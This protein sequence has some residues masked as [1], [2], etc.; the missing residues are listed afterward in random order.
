MPATR[1][2]IAVEGLLHLKVLRSPHAHARIM[3]IDRTKA[4][5]VPGVVAVYTW[6]DV[7]RRLFSSALHEDHLVDPDDMLLLDNVVRFVGQRVAAVVAETEAR[8]RGRLPRARGR[9]RDPAG[10]VRSGVGDGARR[11]APARQGRAVDD[12]SNIFCTLQGEIGDVAKGFAR[13]RRHPRADLFDHPRAARPSRDARIDRLEGRRQPLACPHQLA[14]AVRRPEEARL[15]HGHSDPRHACLHRARRRR[16]RRQA[17][18]GLRRSRAVRRD[19][20]R[21]PGEV[22]MDP[23]GRIH[24]RHD[25]APDDDQGEDRRAG[26]TARSPRS[27]CRS[28][29]TPA[30]TAATAARP[31]ARRWRARSRP[32]AARTRSGI[33]HAVYTNMTPAGGFRGYG[34]SQTTFAMECAIDELAAL[35]DIDP[36]AMRRKNVVQ[37]RRQHRIDLEGAERRELR[38]L[39]H[40]RMPR[41]RRARAE[42]GQRRRQA[43][44]RR[45]GPRAPA[46][47]WPCWNAARRPS[48]ARARRCS[49]CRTAPIISPAARPRWATASPPRTSR[50][51]RRSLGTRAGDIDII[52]ADTDRTPY[53]TGTFASTGTV[54][55]GKAVHLAAEAMRD[56]ILDFASRHTGVPM[57]PVPP[58]QRRA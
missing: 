22:G 44:R 35:L 31:W 26:R 53:D 47:R 7:P 32:I 46:L 25:A 36:F 15:H 9:I 13:G 45:N 28:S 56:D 1:W 58:R 42:E 5:A 50:S 27:T 51:P 19:E 24:R 16:L 38:Q 20:A 6:E 12:S 40:R 34:A 8:G 37:A 57:R 33:G 11:A 39:R 54:V 52:N 14:G 17:G 21:P 30:P 18:D 41:H 29:P 10:G 4:L 2:I 23:R 49:C 43:R 48:T 55:G 3:T